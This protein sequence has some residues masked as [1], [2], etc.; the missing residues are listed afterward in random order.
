MIEALWS[1][2]FTSNMG[3]LG[4]GVV[5][6][7]TERVFGGDAQ[8]FY[9]GNYKSING[10]I[11]GSIKVTHFSGEV[12]SVFGNRKIFNLELTGI[13]EQE[14]FEMRGSMNESPSDLITV[15]L[16]RRAELP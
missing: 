3:V 14:S 12:Y 2:E 16:T 10:Q 4:A 1:V 9:V 11:V 13:P 6:F 15:R 8:Y 5:V 7:E